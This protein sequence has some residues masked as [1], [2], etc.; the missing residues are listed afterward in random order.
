MSL[1]FGN[2]TE[3][4][5]GYYQCLF[6]QKATDLTPQKNSASGRVNDPPLQW[7]L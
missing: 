4:E 2:G 3:C 7:L 1:P 6:S 5:I